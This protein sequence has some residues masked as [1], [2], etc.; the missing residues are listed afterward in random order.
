MKNLK[1]Y[2]A[3]IQGQIH[4]IFDKTPKNINYDELSKE[5]DV[6]VDAFVEFVDDGYG[7]SFITAC[8]RQVFLTY[9]DYIRR[10]V[11][12]DEFIK[13]LPIMGL[14]F[15][16]RISLGE[17]DYRTSLKIAEEVQSSIG[18]IN[19]LGWVLTDYKLDGN[20]KKGPY[21]YSSSYLEYQFFKTSI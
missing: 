21:K 20:T 14:F 12:Y 1:T 8:G 3:Q 19:D 4:N 6:I 18:R 5:F 13:A 17:S 2:E 15:T 9:D 10:G 7:L 11:N 16:V